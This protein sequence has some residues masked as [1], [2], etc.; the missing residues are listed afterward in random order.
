MEREIEILNEKLDYIFEEI[1]SL[2]QGLTRDM[3]EREQKEL[4]NKLETAEW[5][6][7]N[8]REDLRWR[9]EN[10]DERRKYYSSIRDR[11]P[12]I[13]GPVEENHIERL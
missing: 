4:K 11:F 10:L 8:H 3:Y 5:D 9:M 12:K 7:N 13:C 6:L 1:M 2:K